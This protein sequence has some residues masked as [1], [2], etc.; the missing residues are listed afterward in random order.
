[1]VHNS[2]SLPHRQLRNKVA[3]SIGLIPGS[4]PHRQLRNDDSTDY[5]VPT[6]SL[7]HRQLRNI[8]EAGKR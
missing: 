2:R 1:M 7:P 6:S 8:T 3:A 5:L 4:L